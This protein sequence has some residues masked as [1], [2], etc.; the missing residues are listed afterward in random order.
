MDLLET[1]DLLRYFRR[2]K[3]L[4]SY[5]DNPQIFLRQLRDHDLIP[6][7]RY[8]MVNRM[9]SKE[10]IKDEIYDIL[11]KIER[12]K[13]DC[14]LDFWKCI[15]IKDIM[16]LYP[17]LQELYNNLLKEQEQ[18]GPSSQ[19]P[20]H[21]KKSKKTTFSAPSKKGERAGVRPKTKKFEV[22]VTCG[23]LTGTLNKD[24]L[25]KGEEC[26]L[27]DKQWFTPPEF[28]LWAGIKSKNWRKSIRSNGK[29]LKECLK[30]W[31]TYPPRFKGVA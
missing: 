6:E 18:P 11:D 2:N 7:D 25:T 9:K 1:E 4:M 13:S 8:Q 30:K 24:K 16:K 5:M 12:E 27:Y 20:V 23:K 14:I 17:T 3:T 31:K 19:T 28:E 29:T 26:I 10:K 22:P 21:K 15:F